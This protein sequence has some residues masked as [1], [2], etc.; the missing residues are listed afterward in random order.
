MPQSELI[1]L[2]RLTAFVIRRLMTSV[3]C[4]RACVILVNACTCK[5]TGEE[6]EGEEGGETKRRRERKGEVITPT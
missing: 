4:S 2:Y 3:E 1:S 6:R 5:E